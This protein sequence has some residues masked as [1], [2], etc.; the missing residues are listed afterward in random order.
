MRTIYESIMILLVML[1]IM[2][3]WTENTYDSTINWIVWGIFF[4]D[5][6]IRII[7][8]R[9]KWGFIKQNPF[10]LIAIIPF[11]QFFQVA[12]IVR[13]FYLFRIKTITKY[14]ITPHIK[15]WSYRT[16]ALIIMMIFGLLVIEAIWIW[17]IENTVFTYF[18]GLYVVFGHLLFFGHQMFDIENV[19]S[20][21]ALTATSVVGIVVQGLALQWFFSKAEEVYKSYKNNKGA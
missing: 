4:C 12:R 19:F 7:L 18:N 16:K 6:V 17:N 20:I 15:K 5:F 21:W 9:D 2:T 10:L 14:Y 8:T 13:I 3:L 1:T 11:D